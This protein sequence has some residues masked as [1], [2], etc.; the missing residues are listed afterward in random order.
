VFSNLSELRVNPHCHASPISLPSWVVPL[1][2]S[3]RGILGTWRTCKEE[4]I[5]VGN[6]CQ[7]NFPPYAHFIAAVCHDT[8]RCQA[9]IKCDRFEGSLHKF[10]CFRIFRASNEVC[11]SPLALDWNDWRR[12]RRKRNFDFNGVTS[13]CLNPCD[14]HNVV[15]INRSGAEI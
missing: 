4:E 15:N 2:T 11:T 9:L 13:R 10:H 14:A 5:V 3:T 8:V 6:Y 7:Q 12:I 1:Q